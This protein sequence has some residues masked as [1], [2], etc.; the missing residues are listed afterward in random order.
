MQKLTKKVNTT[1]AKNELKAGTPEGKG[2]TEVAFCLNGIA[3][4]R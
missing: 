1:Q 2:S 3:E 4:L